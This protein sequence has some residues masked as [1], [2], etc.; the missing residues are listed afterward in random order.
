MI[1][2]TRDKIETFKDI[3][4]S[5]PIGFQTLFDKM[6]EVGVPLEVYFRMD[7][8]QNQPIFRSRF[9]LPC[10]AKQF[11]DF[12]N[13][14]DAQVKYSSKVQDTNYVAKQLNANHKILYLSYKKVIF[15]GARDLVYMRSNRVLSQGEMLDVQFSVDSPDIPAMASKIRC[16]LVLSGYHAKEFTRDGQVFST[17]TTYNHAD[18]KCSIPAYIMKPFVI[19]N[20]KN[21]VK[22]TFGY[23]SQLSQA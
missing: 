20:A 18:M 17:I 3:V 6:T 23:F 19:S 5:P 12:L 10:S 4:N 14:I 13:D 21:F 22:S 7:P 2:K 8:L 11:I 9:E 1:S 15:A 16:I